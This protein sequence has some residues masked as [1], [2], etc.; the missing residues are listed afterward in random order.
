[1]SRKQDCLAGKRVRFSMLLAAGLTLLCIFPFFTD[2]VQAADK[3]VKIGYYQVANFQ[4]IREDGSYFGFCYDYYMQLQKYTKWDYEFI[5]ASYADCMKMLLNGEIDVLAGV[6]KTPEREEQIAFT[7]YS[8]TSSQNKLFAREDNQ[9]LYYESYDTFDGA[10]IAMMQGTLVDEVEQYCIAHDFTAEIVFYDTL[11][12]MTEA[13][14]NGE[15]D[16]VCSSSIATKTGT[17]IVG[18][19]D[20][21]PLYFVTP[22]DEPEITEGLNNA[23]HKI[24]DNNPDFYNQMSEKY[25]IN[26]ANATA[27]FTREESEYIESGQKVYIIVNPDWAPITWYDENSNSYRGIFIDVIKKIEDYSGLEYVFCTEEEYSQLV[28][29][30][31][32]VENNALGILADD[33]N[34]AAMQNVVMTNHV[35]DSSVVM[36]SKRGTHQDKL[37]E[38]VT[39]AMPKR[40]YIAYAMKD[41]LKDKTVVEYDTVEDCL[42]AVNNGEVDVTYINELA[43]TYYLSMLEYSNLFATANTGYYENL[44]FAVY[45]DGNAP[46]LGIIDKSLL[47][48]GS[49]D[50]NQIVVQNT[51]AEERFSLKGI[52]YTNPNLTIA[53][54]GVTFVVI[55]FIG[56][57]IYTMLRKRK[58]A[59]M[60]LQKEAEVRNARTEF[61]MMIS[62]E[63]RTPLN[64]IVGYLNLVAEEHKKNNWDMEYV[65]R[66]QNAAKQMTEIAEDMLDYTRISSEAVE[67]KEEIFDLKETIVNVDQSIILKASQKQQKYR[68]TVHD[69]SYEYVVGDHLRVAQIFQN[70]LSNGVKFTEPGGTVEADIREELVEEN[71]VKLIFTCRDTGK[72][73]SEEFIEKICAP[74]N[75]NDKAY[76]RTHGGLGLGLY[77]TQ[78]FINAMNGTMQVESKLGEGSCFTVTISLRRP[79]SQEI[80]ENHIDCSHVRAIAAG[81]NPEDNKNLKDL[82]KRLKIK[83][84]T[85]TESEKLKK[86]IRTRLEGQYEY[87]LCII[88]GAMVQQNPQL[89]SQVKE[90]EHAPLIFVITSDSRLIDALTSNALAD[91]ILYKPLFQSV[92]FDAVMDVFGEYKADIEEREK[93][94]FHGMEAMIVEDNMVNADILSRVLKSANINVTV[95]EN[96]QIA[97]DRFEQEEE[98][99]FQVIFM[100]IQMP[101]M[102][103]YEAT[104]RIRASAKAQGQKIPIIAVSANAFSEDVENSMKSGMNAHLSKPISGKRIYHAIKQYV[105][106]QE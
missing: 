12:Q 87:N 59:E 23:L 58:V 27:T 9:A 71:K 36:V 10:K 48:L 46:L 33:N 75:Q 55:F 63:L 21:Q 96:G 85:V 70:I 6:G 92:L 82:L 45:K 7:N 106:N 86:R 84:D 16:I 22:I 67:L 44:A 83:C 60:E 104:E 31:P 39:V 90:N 94:D 53:A 2:H 101:V 29:E 3:K 32:G 102:D 93:E 66:T 4:E 5:E 56:L 35:V 64:A 28:S 54:I 14:L 62:H 20:K 80:I 37:K 103:G 43:A 73:M 13:L 98:G 68:I 57:A 11:A 18:R 76:S 26:G 15:V 38:K 78:Y 24:I 42:S 50:I 65:K 47:C 88:D 61:F 19:M 89:I 49:N 69:F 72:G 97:V 105:L 17:K 81:E 52:Y 51:I 91:Q 100:D 8:V 77:L 79:S 74:F 95:C 30:N 34:W 41:T 40:F 99:R 1:M 25:M